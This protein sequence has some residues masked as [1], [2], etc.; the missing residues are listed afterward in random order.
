MPTWLIISIVGLV[1]FIVL[2]I[3]SA[4]LNHRKEKDKHDGV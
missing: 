1:I 3:V 4:V 2:E